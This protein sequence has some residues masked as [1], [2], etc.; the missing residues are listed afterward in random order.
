MQNDDEES[1]I[2]YVISNEFGNIFKICEHL[3]ISLEWENVVL[4]SFA[5]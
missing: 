3:D 4:T 1:S 2:F 5:I